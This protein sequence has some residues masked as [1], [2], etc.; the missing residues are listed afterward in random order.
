MGNGYNS[1]MPVSAGGSSRL[2]SNS[3]SGGSCNCDYG[4]GR[5]DGFVD[6]RTCQ[7]FPCLIFEDN[8][9]FINHRV[10]EH[11]LTAGGGGNWEFQFYTNNRTN[12]YTRDG[13]LYIKPTL[14]SDHFGTEY[15]EKG[16]LDLWGSSAADVC[17]SNM[18]WGCSR[19]GQPGQIVNPIQSARLRSSRGFNFRYGKVEVEAKLPSGDWLWPAIWML[20][21]LN[22]YGKWPASGEIDIM[23]SRGNL[24]YHD[25]QGKSLGA[26]SVGSTL[27]FGGDFWTNQWPKAH[28]EVLS[29]SGGTFADDFHKYG[30]EWDNTSITFTLD[31]QETLKVA[32]GPGGFWEFGGLDQMKGHE[33]PWRAGSHMAPFDQEF[34]LVLNVAV[35]GVGFF[36]DENRNA[37]YPKPWQDGAGHESDRFW[38]A[39]N[40]W[41]PTWH[42]DSNNGEDAAMK[43]NYVRVWKTKP[44]P[45]P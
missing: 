31:G 6:D 1:G 33:N 34:Y 25:P 24:N 27:H 45:Q 40:L 12:S 36:K 4:P 15:L 30:V 38:A 21:R 2:G 18:D 37:P 13:I 16:K 42:P 23:E 19:E 11:E 29:Q 10:W 41:Y 7:S 14:T 3:G 44:D 26:D 20:P 5:G 32:P 17:T 43:V 22:V 39:R 9:D 28:K 35:G 8:F